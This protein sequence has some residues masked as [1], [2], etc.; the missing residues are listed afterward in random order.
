MKYAL[1]F[2]IA[3]AISF[4]SFAQ[5]LSIDVNRSQMNEL[6]QAMIEEINLVRTNPKA[7]IPYLRNY[8]N[9]V[10]KKRGEYAAV[11][12]VIQTLMSIKPLPALEPMDCLFESAKNHASEMSAAGKFDYKSANGDRPFE[13]ISTT[14]GEKVADPLFPQ[15]FA[16]RAA[17]E[18][19]GILNLAATGNYPYNDVRKMNIMLMT[20]NQGLNNILNPKWKYVSTF[21]YATKSKE[22]M[23]QY[24]TD[25]FRANYHWIQSFAAP[26]EE[27]MGTR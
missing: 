26:R 5:D 2:L 3:V 8:A 15:T 9:E 20:E 13:R 23:K 24:N 21:T 1:T 10:K 27:S 7:Y 12:K 4:S 14:C 22:F 25:V 17:G 18:T 11:K 19:I 16:Q 6:E